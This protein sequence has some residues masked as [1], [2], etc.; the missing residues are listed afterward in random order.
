[1]RARVGI[2]TQRCWTNTALAAVF[3]TFDASCLPRC[4]ETRDDANPDARPEYGAPFPDEGRPEKDHPKRSGPKLTINSDRSLV[5]RSK[6]VRFG[7]NLFPQGC[8]TEFLRNSRASKPDVSFSDRN[9]IMTRLFLIIFGQFRQV[10]D[11]LV[12]D[13]VT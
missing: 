5:L 10:D 9:L 6:N 13:W 8:E 3:D 2:G 12:E 4:V 1:M 11:T 7:R